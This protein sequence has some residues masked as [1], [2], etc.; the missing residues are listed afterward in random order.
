MRYYPHFILPMRRSRG[1]A[2]GRRR[3]DEAIRCRQLW[4]ITFRRTALRRLFSAEDANSPWT[5]SDLVEPS[6]DRVDHL[7]LS[8]RLQARPT[9]LCAD[10][11]A[12]RHTLLADGVTGIDL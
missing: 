11:C 9:G 3:I 2:S 4:A 8:C 6:P 12:V 10:R 5:F 1:F 7:M